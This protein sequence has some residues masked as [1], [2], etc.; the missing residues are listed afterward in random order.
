[1]TTLEVTANKKP[2]IDFAP[3]TV[4]AEVLQ[5]IATLLGTIRYTVPYDRTIGMNPTY[6]DDPTPATRARVTAD[7]I[8]VLRTHEPRAKVI[9]VLFNEDQATGNLIPTARVT[10]NG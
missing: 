2:Q 3:S 1:M 4:E 5:N 6:L 8:D 7:I 10:V 9:E